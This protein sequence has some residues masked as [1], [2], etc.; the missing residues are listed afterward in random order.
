ME[1]HQRITALEEVLS[2]RRPDRVGGERQSH[3]SA[4]RRYE[5]LPESVL[6]PPTPSEARVRSLYSKLSAKERAKLV[7]RSMKTSEPEDPLV[8]KTMPPEQVEEFNWRIGLIRGVNLGLG[9]LTFLLSET[10]EKVAVLL[11]LLKTIRA[12]GVVSDLSRVLLHRH[13]KEPVTQSQYS[14]KLESAH[15]ELLP[16]RELAAWEAEDFEG[17]QPGELVEE[18][19]WRRDGSHDEVPSDEAWARVVA[20]EQARLEVLVAEGTLE[21]VQG[22]EGTRI[23]LGSYYAWKGQEVP[24]FSEFAGGFDIRPDEEATEIEHWQEDRATLERLLVATS[25]DE[26]P[27]LEDVSR[28]GSWRCQAEKA[29]KNWIRESI[30]SDWAHAEA[31]RELIEEIREV[32]DGEDPATPE[33]RRRLEDI[34]NRIQELHKKSKDLVGNYRLPKP[35]DENRSPVR[36]LVDMW[37]PE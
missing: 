8:Q 31:I 28:T 10:V 20:D 2:P 14:Q 30:R 9:P 37:I 4:S 22:Q 27:L 17:W 15:Q 36:K 12:L 26:L 25:A 23:R 21:A 19:S 35:T 29:L 11:I 5:P 7:L 16:I 6:N 33:L 24:V 3:R 18:P 13:A 32:F 1:I 34:A